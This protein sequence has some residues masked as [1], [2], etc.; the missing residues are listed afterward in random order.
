MVSCVQFADLPLVNSV[1]KLV[2]TTEHK[3]NDELKA[4]PSYIKNQRT[5]GGYQLTR[6][7]ST[8]A[9]VAKML[10]KNRCIPWITPTKGTQ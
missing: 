9:Y 10:H 6:E 1:D 4:D 2:R 8:P 3:Q 7:D 5:R